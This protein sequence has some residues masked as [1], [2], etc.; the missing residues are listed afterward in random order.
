M[1]ILKNKIY[2]ESLDKSFK[3]G[4]KLAFLGELDVQIPIYN[5]N[6]FFK[7]NIDDFHVKKIDTQFAYLI[8]ERYGEI[9]SDEIIKELLIQFFNKSIDTVFPISNK[10]EIK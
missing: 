6:S 5:R 1:K 4:Y 7:E 9:L 10:G 3:A 8:R 2:Q